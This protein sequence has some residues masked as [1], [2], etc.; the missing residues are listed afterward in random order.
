[1][2]D[3]DAGRGPGANDSTYGRDDESRHLFPIGV[4]RAAHHFG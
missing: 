2:E 1:M 3:A 4:T